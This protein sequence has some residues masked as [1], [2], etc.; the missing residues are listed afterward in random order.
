[1]S[2]THFSKSYRSSS[3]V[4]AIRS[5]VCRLGPI[6]TIKF[7]DNHESV[8]SSRCFSRY[9][10]YSARTRRLPPPDLCPRLLFSLSAIIDNK[11]PALCPFSSGTNVAEKLPLV[12]TITAICVS[13]TARKL[14]RRRS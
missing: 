4:L 13:R 7:R 14:R 11:A 3:L 5:L 8:L 12:I 6:T 2:V 10:T 9:E 1:M